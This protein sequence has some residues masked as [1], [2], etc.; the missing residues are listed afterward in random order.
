M[1]IKMLLKWFLV[2]C[3]AVII[4]LFILTFSKPP[5]LDGINFSTSVY[6]SNHQL[7]RL[8]TSTDQKYRL[9]ASLSE[10]P[11][12]VIDATLLKEDQYFFQHRG[13]N[14]WSMCRAIKN[15]Y[16]KR[17]RVVGASTITMQVARLRYHIDSHHVLGKL[18]QIL[19]AMKLELHYTKSQILEAY[20]NLAPYGNNIEGIKAASLIYY[21]HPLN[22]LSLPQVLTLVVIPQNPAVRTPQHMNKLAQGRLHLFSRWVEQH[23]NDQQ[24]ASLFQLPLALHTIKEL[25]FVAPHFVDHVLK[26]HPSTSLIQTTLDSNL[27]NMVSSKIRQY[28][29][30]KSNLGMQNAAA[31][32]VD[33]RDMSVKAMVGS[34]DFFNQSISGQINGTTIARSPGSSLKP[35]IYA[36][37]LDQG[38]IHPATV[39]KDTPM[40]FGSYDPENFDYHFLGPLK[41]KDALILSRNIPAIYLTNIIKNPSFYEFL[42][43]ADIPL[44]SEKE[45]GLA[46]ILGDAEISMVKLVSL[47]AMLANQGIYRE[48]RFWKEQPQ[49]KSKR[50]LSPEASFLTLDMLK[51]NLRPNQLFRE[52]NSL[53]ISWKTGTSSRF[54]DGWSV[55]VFGPYVL[56]VWIG[57]FD[58]SGNASFVGQTAAAPLFFSIIDSIVAN[59]NIKPLSYDLSKLHL[60]RLKVCNASGLLETHACPG[61]YETWFIPGKSPIRKDTVF[62]EVMINPDTG[63]RTCHIDPKNTFEIYEFWPSDVLRLFRE[64]GISRRIPPEVDSSCEFKHAHEN[65][66]SPSIT[67]PR[68]TFIYTIIKDFGS[69]PLIANVDAD[70]EELFWFSNST[71]IGKSKRDQPLLWHP[72]PGQYVIRAINNFGRSDS[73]SISVREVH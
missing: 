73:I 3:L 24:Y 35:F 29:S 67:S 38:I 63:K 31:L 25:P 18:K 51:D 62:R 33:T 60:T 8:T 10:I 55:G 26:T 49:S 64:A 4:S 50:L 56:A 36:L 70:V 30:H 7:L 19:Y 16:I 59:Q 28:I 21:H 52:S 27:Q 61:T 48:V 45:Y 14:P 39:L 53:P 66:L 1:K 37:A 72:H 17:E 43:K 2:F 68:N 46:L 42:Q 5:L 32:L 54:R 22:E 65:G 9:F 40:H 57:N 23:P 71:F 41:A 34:G 58:N 20:F 6:D 47:Y 44:R 12:S 69:I 13:I 11:Q 15:T